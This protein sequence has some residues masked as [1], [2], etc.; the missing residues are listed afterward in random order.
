[1]SGGAENFLH[2]LE[3]S[4]TEG[5]TDM[6]NTMK[7]VM[8][9][10]S[11]SKSVLDDFSICESI[12]NGEVTL[13]ARDTTLFVVLKDILIKFYS[14]HV[15]CVP[16]NVDCRKHV[17]T[18]F[19]CLLHKLAIRVFSREPESSLSVF[20]VRVEPI[21][22]SR[23]MEILLSAALEAPKANTVSPPITIDLKCVLKD[24]GQMVG[25]PKDKGI[26][27]FERFEE[28]IGSVETLFLRIEISGGNVKRGTFEVRKMRL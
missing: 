1:M 26:G 18:K 12:I 7:D 24:D 23:V 5:A 21:V 17:F 15:S 2:E 22:F 9:S 3:E 16:I 14:L 25:Q 28:S 6:V 19:V 4:T 13:A 27:M 11:I 8:E 20:N 10:C